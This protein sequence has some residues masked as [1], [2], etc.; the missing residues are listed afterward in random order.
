MSFHF[1]FCEPPIAA[2]FF[3]KTSKVSSTIQEI[4]P[5]YHC[6]RREEFLA[7]LSGL[8]IH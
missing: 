6:G 3:A 4:A 8:C 7:E 5:P 1:A 2:A